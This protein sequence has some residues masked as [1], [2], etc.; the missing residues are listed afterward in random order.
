MKSQIFTFVYLTKKKA[1][2]KLI[3]ACRMPFLGDEFGGLKKRLHESP[4]HSRFP[5]AVNLSI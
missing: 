4:R 5:L 1:V 3:L 2:W